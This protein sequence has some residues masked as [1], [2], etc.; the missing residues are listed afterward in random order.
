MP[1]AMA[2]E[3]ELQPLGIRVRARR[4][5]AELGLVMTVLRLPL[6]ASLPDTLDELRR[7]YPNLWLDTNQRYPLLQSRRQ[8]YA[9]QAIGWQPLAGCASTDLNL[10]LLDTPVDTDHP[11]LRGAE[12]TQQDFVAREAANSDHGT[13]IAS[14]WLAASSDLAPGLVPRARVKVAAVFRERD[15]QQ[16]TTTEWLL[17]GLNWLLGEEVQVI[18][19][20][21][22]GERNLVL[23]LALQRVQERGVSL[24]AAGGNSGAEAPPVYPAAQP[25]VVAVAATDAANK[26][27]RQGNRGAYL[28]FSAPGVDVWTASRRGKGAYRTGSSYATAYVSA[29]FATYRSAGLDAQAAYARVKANAQ[30][31]GAA[32]KDPLFGWGL[33]RWPD[34]CV[35]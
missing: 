17:D 33:I 18:N 9:P 3:R 29:L 23:E 32:G 20:S 26:A 6:D 12:I 10:G 4:Q 7:R 15:K 2:L 1:Q 14:I 21:L 30:D 8:T 31:L 34:Q 25:G 22:G 11:S 13:A 24:V 27:Y 28:D 16:E 19:L 35:P 5:L